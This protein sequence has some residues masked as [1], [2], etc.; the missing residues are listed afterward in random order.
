[1]IVPQAFAAESERHDA[2]GLFVIPIPSVSSVTTTKSIR[3]TASRSDSHVASLKGDVMLNT[4]EKY[5]QAFRNVFVAN[6]VD[7]TAKSIDFTALQDPGSCQTSNSDQK[8]APLR[9]IALR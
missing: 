6:D 3:M 5:I 8:V 2:V 1:L 9:A 7:I 4:G